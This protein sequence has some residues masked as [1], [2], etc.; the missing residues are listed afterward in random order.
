MFAIVGCTPP[1]A[2]LVIAPSVSVFALATVS[3]RASK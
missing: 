1:A 3:P 2:V